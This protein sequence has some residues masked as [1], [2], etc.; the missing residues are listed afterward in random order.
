MAPTVKLDQ[1]ALRALL[2]SPQGPVWS[3]IQ[4]RTNR[5]LNQARRNAPV[6]EGR[7]RASLAM[8]MR[9]Q[10]GSPVGRVGSNLDY[11]LYVHEGTG[12]EAGRGYI[13]PVRG[14]VLRWPAKNNSGAGARRYKGGA[15]AAYVY[16]KRSRGV[17]A[18]PFLRD[19]LSAAN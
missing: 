9:S 7:L 10:D 8:E 14:R 19:A 6:D 11:A 15:T 16:A 12:I 13:V 18:R 4:R 2:D 17:K 1:S 3:D 5:V